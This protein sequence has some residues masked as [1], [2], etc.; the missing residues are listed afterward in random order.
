L[1]LRRKRALAAAA[2]KAG[3][4]TGLLCRLRQLSAV[5]FQ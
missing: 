1:A 4:W 3:L 2:E 5:N